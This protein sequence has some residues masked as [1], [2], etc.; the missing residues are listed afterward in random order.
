MIVSASVKHRAA[1]GLVRLDARAID[2]RVQPS[3]SS[4]TPKL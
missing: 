4:S 1:L 2:Q 3:G